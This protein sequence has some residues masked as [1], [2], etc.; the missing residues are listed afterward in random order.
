MPYADI[1]ALIVVLAFLIKGWLKGFVLEFFTFAGLITAALAA[2]WIYRVFSKPLSKT[3]GVSEN[4]VAVVLFL[5]TFISIAFLF[6]AIGGALNRKTEG[7]AT[8]NMNRTLGA[9]FGAGKGFLLCGILFLFLTK[10]PM[11]SG[12]GFKIKKGSYFAGYILDFA[13]DLLKAIDKI[14]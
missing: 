11:G 14:I 1:V 10:H 9:L 13:E 4:I 8:K 3:L 6:G 2:A 12:F 5:V 7:M